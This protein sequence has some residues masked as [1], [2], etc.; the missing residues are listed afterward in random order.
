MKKQW[1]RPELVI[2]ERGLPGELVLTSCKEIGGSGAPTGGQ[3]GCDRG[4]PGNCGTCQSR[5]G[6]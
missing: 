2:I 4:D 5:G 3:D 1:T 6:S